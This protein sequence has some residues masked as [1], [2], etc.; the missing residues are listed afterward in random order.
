MDREH[1]RNKPNK[2]HS[3]KTEFNERGLRS[4]GTILKNE[5]IRKNIPTL[6]NSWTNNIYTQLPPCNYTWQTTNYQRICQDPASEFFLNKTTQIYARGLQK[7]RYIVLLNNSDSRPSNFLFQ[8]AKA[9]GLHSVSALFP[10][11]NC[12]S[13]RRLLQDRWLQGHTTKRTRT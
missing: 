1:Q 7:E 6:Y 10:S 8:I 3:E 11:K 12:T 9:R 4:E 13:L 2:G 5:H